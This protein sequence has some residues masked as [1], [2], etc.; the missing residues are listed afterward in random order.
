[1]VIFASILAGALWG[2]VQARRHGG[3]GADIAQYA[4]VWGLIG[5]ILGSA[6]TLALGAL[7]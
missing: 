6:L 7:I 4:A 3:T 1:M 5:A 2:G